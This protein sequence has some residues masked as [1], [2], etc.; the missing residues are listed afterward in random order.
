MKKRN[1]VKIENRG[2]VELFLLLQTEQFINNLYYYLDKGNFRK[3]EPK[4]F[5]VLKKE[6]LNDNEEFGFE[7]IVLFNIFKGKIEIRKQKDLNYFNIKFYKRYASEGHF[8]Y[9]FYMEKNNIKEDDINKALEFIIKGENKI[10]RTGGIYLLK[11]GL[12]CIIKK[13]YSNS[14]IGVIY[15]ETSED[16]EEYIR[17]EDIE[18]LIR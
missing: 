7:F 13:Y 6:Q 3:L 2:K 8:I 16:I 12:V 18:E 9:K 4:L 10:V 17:I 5:R 1:S 15:D 11:N 14:K